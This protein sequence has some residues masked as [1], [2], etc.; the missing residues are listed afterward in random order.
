MFIHTDMLNVL[1]FFYF[2]YTKKPTNPSITLV[3]ACGVVV[4]ALDSYC[5]QRVGGFESPSVRMPLDKAV[6]PQLS[7][8][9]QV[10]VVNG[11]PQE[12]SPYKY[13]ARLSR[14][15]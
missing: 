10:L 15:G 1:I 8:S 5:N 6:C 13:N 14:P 11:Y 3:G 12:F 9:A 2:K 7:L 4:R